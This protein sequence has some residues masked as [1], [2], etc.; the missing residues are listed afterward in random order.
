LLSESVKS[1]LNLEGEIEWKEIQLE[2]Y[3]KKKILKKLK[4]KRDISE[5]I[6]CGSI[7]NEKDKFY[8]L[9]ENAPSKSETFTFALYLHREKGIVDVD[10]LIYREQYG[11]EIDLP[12]FRHQFVGKIKPNQIIFGRTIQGITGAT[13]SSRSITYAIRDLLTI[14][15]V[16]EKKINSI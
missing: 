11:N 13:I 12:M 14:Y 5:T 1:V 9:L 7:Q 15:Q 2:A 8:I 10:V 4:I 3:E 16:I 6:Y